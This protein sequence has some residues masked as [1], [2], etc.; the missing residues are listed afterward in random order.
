MSDSPDFKD[1]IADLQ[2]GVD[3]LG[4]QLSK[5]SVP[6]FSPRYAAHMNSDISSEWAS[7]MWRY[8]T[9]RLVFAVPATL[10]YLMA[11]QYNQNNAAPEGG[12]LSSYIEWRFGQHLCAMVG[13]NSYFN[14]GSRQ[15]EDIVGWGHITACGTIAN[16]ESMWYILRFHW[17]MLVLIFMTAGLVCRCHDGSMAKL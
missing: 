5:H 11:Q 3:F 10:G 9:K 14:S 4:K 13:Y 7:L 16:L 6:F 1:S 15:P 12:P 8:I 2:A 17:K